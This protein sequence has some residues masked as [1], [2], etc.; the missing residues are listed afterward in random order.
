MPYADV[1][2]YKNI[3]KGNVVPDEQLPKYLERASDSID[4][5][6][7]QRLGG[8]SLSTF[9]EKQVRMAVCYQVDYLFQYE[10]IL[11]LNPTSYSIG[12][13]SVAMDKYGGK[14]Y[15]KQMLECLRTTGFMNRYL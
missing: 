8:R 12:D 13:V 14:L 2:F 1:T 7:Y 11:E 15:S 10:T 5:I 6:T 9:Q 3:Y 4:V